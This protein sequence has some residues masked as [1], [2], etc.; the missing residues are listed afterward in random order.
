MLPN[1]CTDDEFAAQQWGS[2]N[3]TLGIYPPYKE[4]TFLDKVS[5][6]VSNI[7]GIGKANPEYNAYAIENLSGDEKFPISVKSVASIFN[8]IT[9]LLSQ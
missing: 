4:T 8:N 6:S 7:W 5:I 1:K 2:S 9:G 3:I